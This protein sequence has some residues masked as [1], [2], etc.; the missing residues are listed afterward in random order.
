MTREEREALSQRICNFYYDSAK[1]SVKTTLNYFKK[2]NVPQIT[3][4]YVLK[5][6]LQ[7]GTTKDPSRNGRPLKLSKKNLNNIVKSVNNR[8]GLSQHKME[9]W[10]KVHYSTISRNLQRRTSIA[11]RK[12]RKAPKMNNEQQQVRVWKNC[13]KLYRKLLNEC[14]L[15]M[16]DE[17]YFKL[18]GNN[19]IGNR[20]FYSTDRATA[21]PKVKFQCKTKFEAKVMIWMVMS[22]KGTSDIYVHKSIQAVNQDTYLK[23]CINKRLLPF[24]AK[25]HSNGNYLFWPDLAQSTLLKYCSTMFD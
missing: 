19:V 1:K 8:C 22:S 20:Y 24:I 15:I 11:I 4:Y 21:P 13:D 14:D 23:E 5:K 3:I 12:R 2:Q 16:D 25:Y 7:Y 6:Y 18:T 9:R 17:K 10:F